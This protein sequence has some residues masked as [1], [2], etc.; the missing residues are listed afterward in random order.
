[1]IGP[2]YLANLYFEARDI[3]GSMITDPFDVEPLAG[4]PTTGEELTALMRAMAVLPRVSY[5]SANDAGTVTD[6]FMGASLGLPEF[7]FSPTGGND[8]VVPLWRVPSTSP[9][10]YRYEVDGVRYYGEWNPPWPDSNVLEFT[11]VGQWDFVVYFENSPDVVP[12]R[13]FPR[14]SNIVI[15]SGLSLGDFETINETPFRFRIETTPP[16]GTSATAY[17]SLA[18]TTVR[19]NFATQ[20]VQVIASGTGTSE[21]GFPFSF[22]TSS[23]ME[24]EAFYEPYV[25][26]VTGSHS[27]TMSADGHND[28]LPFSFSYGNAIG[29]L[30]LNDTPAIKPKHYVPE[31]RITYINTAHD[32]LNTKFDKHGHYVQTSSF[33]M[34]GVPHRAIAERSVGLVEPFTGWYDGG[35]HKIWGLSGDEGY[36]PSMFGYIIGGHVENLVLDDVNFGGRTR[37]ALASYCTASAFNN[38][39]V[40]GKIRNSLPPMYD[41]NFDPASP[42]NT[43]FDYI[44]NSAGIGGLFHAAGMTTIDAMMSSMSVVSNCYARCELEIVPLYGGAPTNPAIMSRAGGLC[45]YTIG[46][47]ST[48]YSASTITVN[49]PINRL[50]VGVSSTP[51]LS[52]YD[53]DVAGFTSGSWDDGQPRTTEQM[54]Y[55]Y[56]EMTTYILWDFDST[57]KID[58]N[59]N[60]GYPYLFVSPQGS[61]M[62]GH[63]GVHGTLQSAKSVQGVIEAVSQMI[64]GLRKAMIYAKTNDQYMPATVT[65]KVDGGYTSVVT[66]VKTDGIY[67][68]MEGGEV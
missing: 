67:V 63:S 56:D 3:M 42:T 48:C 14:L 32:F 34:S 59:T 60:D 13:V 55:P 43:I 29:M 44:N 68:P 16:S 30:E 28:G 37:G 35:G 61:V 51:L 19:F 64:M 24:Y 25:I 23:T 40:T 7:Y 41:N 45:G 11:T 62:G 54:T 52:F 18:S 4:D 2:K 10:R 17:S 47:I 21:N 15:P 12:V 57:W 20:S 6:K 22:S 8:I 49:G 33:D 46:P 31:T 5:H 36:A 50:G 27:I 38:I 66:Y 58:E 53:V 65:G 39:A 9:L 1:M 26:E